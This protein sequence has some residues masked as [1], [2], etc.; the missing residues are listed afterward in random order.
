MYSK[1]RI[2]ISY[3]SFDA[4][5]AKQISIDLELIGYKVW[6]DKWQL[7]V[8]DNIPLEISEGIGSSDFV[9]VLLSEKS[10]ASDW[11]NREWAAKYWSE[12][13]ENKT[14]VLSIL[15]E[16]C[17]I[18][19]LLQGRIY[20]DFTKSYSVGFCSLA[21]GLEVHGANLKISPLLGFEYP[22]LVT[23]FNGAISIDILGYDLIGGIIRYSSLID[24]ALHNSTNIRIIYTKPTRD[25]ISMIA[26]RSAF[27]TTNELVESGTNRAI[28]YLNSIKRKY[29]N[30]IEI[31][32][33]D[34]CPNFGIFRST[35]SDGIETI[36]VKLFPYKEPTG[37]Y[38][39]LHIEKNKHHD[40]YEFFNEQFTKMW[41]SANNS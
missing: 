38:P 36:F 32:P 34:F 21:Q 2:F 7:A 19:T 23:Y 31:R 6:L 39:V 24:E 41:N 11:V 12:I 37:R 30:Q 9:A 14:K 28:S 20:A 18:P 33:I 5:I 27:N 16:K 4:V 26:K 15:L 13:S 29:I 10:V 1:P 40:W 25:N 17:N 3:S 22:D 8:G 35:K